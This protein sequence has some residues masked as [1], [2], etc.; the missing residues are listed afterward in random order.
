MSKKYA[1][2]DKK[3]QIKYRNNKFS[4]LIDDKKKKFN[5][6]LKYT[7]GNKRPWSFNSYGNLS[8]IERA[9]LKSN[10]KSL[11]FFYTYLSISKKRIKSAKKLVK[12]IR[13]DE[14]RSLSNKRR[15][16]R[17]RRSN[18]P[19][20]RRRKSPMKKRRSVQKKVS[21]KLTPLKGLSAHDMKVV[22][23]GEKFGDP[24]RIS[25]SDAKE[26]LGFEPD[27]NRK[28]VLLYLRS[29]HPDK[30]GRFPANSR[31]KRGCDAY[32]KL[33]TRIYSQYYQ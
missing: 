13:E 8:K 30:C 32:G 18:S 31:R 25:Y 6:I 9:A 29:N 28:K 24:T 4:F 21:P 17:R 27:N 7:K 15:R 23:L 5:F 26:I 1:S 11:D 3:V 12:L 19:K 10:F 16:R 2:R 14:K 20:N 22:E 33:V